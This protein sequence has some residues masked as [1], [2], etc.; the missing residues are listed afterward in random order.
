MA[1]KSTSKAVATRGSGNLPAKT[2]IPT[3]GGEAGLNRYLS[4]I[5]KFPLLAPEQEYMLAKRWAEHQ[6]PEAAAK[7]VTSHLRL[8]AKIAMGYRG[9]GLPV[10]ELISE[11]NIGLMQG[12]KKFDAERG[13][14][15]ATYAMWW[16]RASIQEFI[17][18]SWSLVKIGTTANQKKLFFN[19]RRMKGRINAM[20]DGDMK[21]ADVDSIATTLGVTKDEVISMNRRMAMGGDTS[22]NAPLRA[23]KAKASGRTG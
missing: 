9:Y 4:E 2:S 18:R 8:V 19:L 17:L 7:L 6:D 13:F 20:E 16:I 15:L 1:A 11:G 14:R 21:P 5:R 10:A 23:R 22:L 12:V 3:M